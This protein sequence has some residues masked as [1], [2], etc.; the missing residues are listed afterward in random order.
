MYA[1]RGIGLNLVYSRI[2]ELDGAIKTQTEAGK[3]TVFHIFLPVEKS[4]GD[5]V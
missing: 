3:G 4:A 1:G 5:E 2:K